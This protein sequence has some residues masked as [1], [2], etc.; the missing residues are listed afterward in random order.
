MSRCSER[1][2]AKLEDLK[3]TNGVCHRFYYALDFG[4]IIDF[5]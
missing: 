5:V 2:R 3:A 4:I 1:L